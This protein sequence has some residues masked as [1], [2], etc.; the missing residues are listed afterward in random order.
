MLAN[1]VLVGAPL[2]GGQLVASICELVVHVLWFGLGETVA[3]A[4]RSSLETTTAPTDSAACQQVCK[5]ASSVLALLDLVEA[6]NQAPRLGVNPLAPSLVFAFASLLQMLR[7][8]FQRRSVHLA[9]SK[10]SSSS[11]LSDISV[12]LRVVHVLDAVLAAA[13]RLQGGTFA[14]ASK[15]CLS[16]H[17]PEPLVGTATLAEDLAKGLTATVT[18]PGEEHA[19]HRVKRPGEDVDSL[20]SETAGGLHAKQRRQDVPVSA[21]AADDESGDAE[22]EDGEEELRSEVPEVRRT[23]ETAGSQPQSDAPL[24]CS[25]TSLPEAAPSPAQG[26]SLGVASPAKEAVT[27]ASISATTHRA[28]GDEAASA[29]AAKEY[30]SALSQLAISESR[31]TAMPAVDAARDAARTGGTISDPHKVEAQVGSAS[32]ASLSA[33]T[34]HSSADVTDHQGESLELFPDIDDGSP[35]PDLCMDSPSSGEN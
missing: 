25:L 27:S 33:A 31:S 10:S 8:A 2:L 24:P 18:Q 13:G 12:Q 6:L 20:K 19:L 7:Q 26:K 15:P 28:V 30:R 11:A 14:E 17:W 3:Q 5:D 32:Q 22:D 23:T 34:P 35:L 21:E 16:I 9:D 1:V 4:P 29:E